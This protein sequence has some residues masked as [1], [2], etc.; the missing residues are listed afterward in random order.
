[1][2]AEVPPACPLAGEAEVRRLVPAV[3]GRRQRLDDALEVPLHRLRLALELDAPGVREPRARLRLEL[4]EGEVLRRERQSLREV[5]VEVGGLLARDPVDEIERDVVE[6]GITKSMHRPP[7]VVRRGN[8]LEHLEQ[9]R[10]ERL[11]AERD[12]RDAALAQQRRELAA[13]PS[14]GSPRRSPP[15]RPAARRAAA[16]AR[17]DSVND[18][19]PPPTKTVASGVG[20]HAS[21]PL[22]LDQQRVDV[23]AVLAPSRPTTVTK[24]Q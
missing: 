15:R 23:G 3:A 11:R 1:M 8:A 17:P 21:L 14:R 12:A 7:D 2:C 22:E 6:R 13:S 19:V 5:V 10:G 4:V 16:A 24:S 20:E 18:G 9:P